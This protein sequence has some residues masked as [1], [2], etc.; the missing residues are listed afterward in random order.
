MSKKRV[1]VALL[2]MSAAGFSGWQASEGFTDRAVIPTRGDV[3]TIGHGSTR[4][5]DGRPVLMTD[6][7]TPQR[8]AVLARNLL[9]QDEKRFAASLPG[10]ELSQDEFDLYM[11]F[12]GQYGIGNWLKSS[13]RRRL[14]AKDYG[15]ACDALLLYKYAAG[16]DCST[17]GNKRCAGVWTRQLERHRK[18]MD[19]Q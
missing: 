15:P 8:A 10:V 4:Y 2:T 7:I 16:Y 5:E 18:C 6:R 14:L 17:P 19:A 11:D 13:M 3:P 9:T 1:A 12:V